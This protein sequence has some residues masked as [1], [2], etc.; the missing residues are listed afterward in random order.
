MDVV[1]TVLLFLAAFLVLALVAAAV[2]L[3]VQKR[4]IERVAVERADDLI[5][6]NT[7][8]KSSA[9]NVSRIKEDDLETE[10][11]KAA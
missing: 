4:S 11:S 8:A 9:G 2:F 1:T 7:V 10:V 5:A 3:I 6:E